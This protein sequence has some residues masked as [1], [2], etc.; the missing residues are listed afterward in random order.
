MA[1]LKN[2]STVS[3]YLYKLSQVQVKSSKH[4]VSL[5]LQQ[6][7]INFI[8]HSFHLVDRALPALLF[9][10]LLSLQSLVVVGAA[11]GLISPEL[12]GPDGRPVTLADLCSSTG[13][14]SGV[15]HCG[16]CT[17]STGVL[18]PAATAALFKFGVNSAVLPYLRHLVAT[19]PERWQ[20][21]RRGP[22]T[23]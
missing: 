16:G 21:P 10:A 23:A 13:S 17:L 1:G 4:P 19:T 5:L 18:S 9:A 14:S 20:H 15:S 12:V 22:P 11:D 8:R 2:C 7:V 3:V 6:A